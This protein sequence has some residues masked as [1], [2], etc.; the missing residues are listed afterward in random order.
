M[1]KERFKEFFT[2]S[3][4]WRAVKRTIAVCIAILLVI[5]TS[6]ILY[7]FAVDIVYKSWIRPYTTDRVWMEEA[8]SE[9]FAFQKMCYSNRSRI[10]DKSEKKVILNKVNWIAMSN[11]GDSL[12]VFARKGKRGYINRFTGK[13]VIPEVYSRAWVFS[14]GLAAVEKDGE[15]LFIDHSGNVVI[16]RNF[17]AD[18]ENLKYAFKHGYCVMRST[19]NRKLGL[20]DINGDWVLD[21]GYDVLYY[22]KGF[23]VAETDGQS[24]LYTG[25]LERMFPFDETTD[26]SLYDNAIEV[27]YADHTAKRFDFDGNV[28]VDFIIDEVSNLRYETTEVRNDL[29]VPEDEYVDTR[30]YGVAD[31]QCYM[32]RSSDCRPDYYGLLNRDGE[33]VTPPMYTDI[34]AIGK[35]LYLCQPDGVILDNNGRRVSTMK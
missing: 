9:R 32:V 17:I 1:K 10:Y 28:I 24:R 21:A 18:Y 14:E 29:T 20:I 22:C 23:W 13:V 7:A 15:L 16:D 33:V 26:I 34:E 4:F 19:D 8:L 31:C 5:F 27:R 35:G 30:V 6:C 25:D 12:A 3:P 11:D 2:G